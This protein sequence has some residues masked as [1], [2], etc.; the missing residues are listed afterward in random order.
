MIGCCCFYGENMPLSLFT[1]GHLG[2]VCIWLLCT[3]LEWTWGCENVLDVT[4]SFPLAVGPGMGSLDRMVNLFLVSWSNAPLFLIMA[5]LIYN[6][7]NSV[8][9]S[10]FST[11]LATFVR[12]CRFWLGAAVSFRFWFPLL[13][14]SCMSSQQIRLT[15]HLQGLRQNIERLRF[16]FWRSVIQTPHPAV[17]KPP[18]CWP[19]PTFSQLYF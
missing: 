14:A 8:C 18:Y 3:R 7:P 19:H 12:F 17:P 9:A 16:C 15:V 6:F 13:Y 10:F 4:I 2:W 1:E 5:I 11:S